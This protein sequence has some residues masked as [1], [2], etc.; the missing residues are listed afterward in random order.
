MMLF[1]I[2]TLLPILVF[3]Y[4]QSEQALSREVKTH[5]NE[6]I[7]AVQMTIEEA[8]GTD[9][10][11]DMSHINA[12]LKSLNMKGINTVSI[13]NNANRIVAS[14]NPSHVGRVL[15]EE[16]KRAATEPGPE[17]GVTSLK[18]EKVIGILSEDEKGAYNFILPVV[19]RDIR[20]GYIL[21]NINSEVLSSFLRVR[22]IKRLEAVLLVFFIGIVIAYFLSRHYTR[23][24][25]M[26]AQ[27]AMMIASGNFDQ[28]VE[29]NGRDEMRQLFES[30]NFMVERLRESRN[31]E[32]RLREAEHLA[33]LG[34]LSRNIA[35]EIR[36]PLNFINL[37]IAHIDEKFRPEDPGTQE[38]FDA[39]VGGIK[40]EIQRLNKL[41]SD[42]LDY[43]KP[44]RL[45]LQK[46]EIERL[47]DEIIDL[48]RARAETE[49]ISIVKEYHAG[50]E[51]ELDRDL[52][53]S[54]ILNVVSNAFQAMS[55]PGKEKVLTI[56]TEMVGEKLILSIADSGLGVPAANLSKIF[57]PF[58]STKPDGLGLGLSITKRI[59]E[60]HGGDIEFRSTEGEGSEVRL[61]LPIT[62]KGFE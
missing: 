36:N 5:A 49:G 58:F 51:L 56:R 11:I 27:S 60:E 41:V 15:T 18:K 22:A 7:K 33:G 1:L 21:L 40:L 42:Y 52:I 34:Q 43:S 9:D 3:V 38:R 6:L 24:I 35:H 20:F 19:A 31:Y 50:N 32:R 55:M 30:F 44:I 46:V 28:K 2:V 45:N 17:N 10:I 48:I 57:D 13:V 39:L 26:L 12:Y 62:Q 23:P 61:L 25:K 8:T 4:R 54:C 14:T 16:E 59:T 47:L 29:V 53:K 37:S